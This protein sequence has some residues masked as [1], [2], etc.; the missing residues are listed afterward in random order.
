MAELLNR[1][2]AAKMLGVKAW[3][4]DTWRK[5]G[6]LPFV[7]LGERII[8]FRIEDIEAFVASRTKAPPPLPVSEG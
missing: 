3:T 7:A 1:T 5:R 2:E 4:V 6:E 8:R